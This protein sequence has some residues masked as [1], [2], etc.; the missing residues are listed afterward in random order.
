MKLW[1]WALGQGV[2]LGVFAG[3]RFPIES[4]PIGSTDCTLNFNWLAFAVVFGLGVAGF[5]GVVWL[6]R[7]FGGGVDL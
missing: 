1:L 5:F 6:V 2:L 7:R 3:V 4:C